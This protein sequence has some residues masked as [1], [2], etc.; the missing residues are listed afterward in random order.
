VHPDDAL[1]VVRGDRQVGDR[2]RRGVRGDDG[3]RSDDPADLGEEVALEVEP[4]RTASMT[5]WQPASSARDEVT[6]TRPSSSV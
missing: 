6:L 3:V 5:R 4:L 1:G 2:Q